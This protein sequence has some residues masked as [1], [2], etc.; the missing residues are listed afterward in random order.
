[1]SD[2]LNLGKLIDPKSNQQRDAI[3]IAVAPVIA[4]QRLTPGKP[5]GFEQDSTTYV[6]GSTHKAIGIVDPFLKG[7]VYN[8]EHFW[9]FL[10]PNTITSLRHD[11]TH[12]AFDPK[13]IVQNQDRES[14]EIWMREFAK[15]AGL[16]YPEAIEA[17]LHYLATGNAW[18]QQGSDSARS[19]FWEENV[20]EKYW[21]AFGAL[22]GKTVTTEDRKGQVFCCNC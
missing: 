4:R 10:F 9:M 7:P 14:A 17:G 6:Y 1:M 22:T 3:H 21:D 5:I 16:E 2:T 19:K 12:P 18:V 8:G 20:S 13:P 11:W 15:E